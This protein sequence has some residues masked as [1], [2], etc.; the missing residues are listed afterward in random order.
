MAG[1]VQPP[2]SGGAV[3]S[4]EPAGYTLP[5]RRRPRTT[6]GGG[7]VAGLGIAALI[8]VGAALGMAVFS[9][10]DRGPAGFGP[11]SAERVDRE[12]ATGNRLYRSGELTPI[13][14]RAPR[15][16]PGDNASMRHFMETL[17][18]CLDESWSRQF[19]KADVDFAP[20]QRIFW[21]GSGRSPCGSYPNPGAAAFYCPANRTMYV[22]VEHI[23]AASG[24]EPV[25]NYAV[26][27]RVLA[28]EYGHHVQDRAGILAYGHQEMERPDAQARNDASRRIELQAQCFAGVF[29][30][31]E[32]GTLPMTTAQYQALMVDVQGR[33]DDSLPPE[34]RDHGS[35]RNYAG[36]VDAGFRERTLAVCNTWTAPATDVD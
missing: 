17:T 9:G 36:W 11:S 32:R 33:G 10:L 19:D 25:G 13:G 31:A 24:D 20:P 8:F 15:I 21:T 6:P 26:Y 1:H 14:C 29:L 12:I 35:G 34:R 30:G 5:P 16:V 4:R 23:I 18:K 27:A 7:V 2:R 22:G 3:A 28:H